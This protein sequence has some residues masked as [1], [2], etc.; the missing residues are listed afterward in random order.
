MKHL[1]Q[2]SFSNPSFSFSKS[3]LRLFLISLFFTIFH[4]Q[5]KNLKNYPTYSFIQFFL[6]LFLQV[7]FKISLHLLFLVFFQTDLVRVFKVYF[8]RVMELDSRFVMDELESKITVDE[9]EL[10][11]RDSFQK[12]LNFQEFNFGL[13]LFQNFQSKVFNFI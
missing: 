10:L 1:D 7:A 13:D 8:V 6:F 2:D 9:L 4:H 5:M 3:C 11:Q 12:F